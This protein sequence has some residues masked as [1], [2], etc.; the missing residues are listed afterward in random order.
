MNDILKICNFP[1]KSIMSRSIPIKTIVDSYKLKKSDEN[2]L[3]SQIK[4]IHLV[5]VLDSETTFLYSREIDDFKFEQILVFDVNLKT[6]SKNI[7]LDRKMHGYFPN[8]TIFVYSRNDKYKLSSADKRINLND[9]N[10][11]VVKDVFASTFFDVNNKELHSMIVSLN[12]DNQQYKDL[13]DL[14]N[15]YQN[16]I[17]SEILTEITGNYPTKAYK[18]K[19]I[20]DSLKELDIIKTQINSLDE[21]EKKAIGMNDKM[22]IHSKR[23]LLLV[24]IDEIIKRF[25]EDC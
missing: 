10:L 14:Y 5:A 11:S 8:P 24:K 12:Y 9:N 25:M 3:R 23:K 18:A 6:T 20:K 19:Y 15:H 17:F 7:S 22:Q 21:E 16:V 1:E 2:L 4:S 13:I